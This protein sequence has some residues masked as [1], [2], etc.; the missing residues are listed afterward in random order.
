MKF[1]YDVKIDKQC[2]KRINACKFIFGEKKRT[3]VYPV[4]QNT[5]K[6]FKKIWTP[7]IDKKFREGIYRIFKIEFPKDFICYI[8]S[9]PYSMDIKGG[10]S[11]SAST[12][13]PIRTIC[14]ESNHYMF[15]KSN[16]KKIYFP[17]YNIEDAKEIFTVVNNIYFQSI[18]ENQDIGWKK[19]WKKRY[20]LLIRWLE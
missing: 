3:Q 19:F 13:T 4:N 11:I 2:W 12:N 16:Y 15:R 8:N 20:K 17:K 6:N 7:K 5:V 1:K 10:I 14:H 9:T 18:M